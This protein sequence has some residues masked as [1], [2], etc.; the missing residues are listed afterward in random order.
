MRYRFIPERLREIREQKALSAPAFAKLIGRSPDTVLH[1][2]RGEYAPTARD[3]E[4][5]CTK[6]GVAP[7]WFFSTEKTVNA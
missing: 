5:I 2:E 4:K 6:C 7:A 1:W 3:L